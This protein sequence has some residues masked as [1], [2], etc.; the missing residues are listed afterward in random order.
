[1]VDIVMF[2]V[3][4]YDVESAAARLAPLLGSETTVISFQNGIDAEDRIEAVIGAGRVAGGVAY[5]SASLG[6]PGEVLHHNRLAKLAFGGR[7]G[8]VTA[9]LQA[10][11]AACDRAGIDAVL[12][13]EIEKTIWEKFLFL[14]SFAAV[15]GATRHAIGPVL[16][17][18]VT[19]QLFVDAMSEI[20]AVAKARGIGLSED[21]VARQLDVA[22]KL[23]PDM[24]ASLL[25]D[26]ERGNRIEIEGLSGAV[27]RLGRALGVP[28][29]VHA[30][31]YAALK[32]HAPGRG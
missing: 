5:L 2:C 31:L 6:A 21:A 20:A 30:A 4:L 9:P 18:P 8:R 25:H 1:P 17:D 19:R 13:P 7:D 24:K 3:K 23:A 16:A 14:A 29:P 27:L 26:L 28:T 10:L 32:L 12:S 22:S 11:K 15:T